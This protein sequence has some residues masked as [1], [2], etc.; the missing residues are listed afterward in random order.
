[1]FLLAS[2]LVSSVS[3]FDVYSE[4]LL[5]LKSE[6]TDDSNSLRDWV[7][8]SHE[9]PSGKIYACSWSGVKCNT[10]STAIIGLNLSVKNLAGSLSGKQF[11]LLT[12]LVD[13]N[14]SYNSFS[15]Q[16]P[17][18][19]FNL[20]NLV[21]LDISRNNFS[22]HFP[23]EV[24]GLH[25]LEV[26]DVFSN[27]FSGQLPAG[28]SEIE[29]LKV[30]NL[31]GSY[32]SGPIPSEYGSFKSLEFIHLAGNFLRGEIPPELGKLKT[33][34]HMEIG[35]NSYEGS[36]PWQ[37]GNMSELQYLDIAGANLSG[38]IPSQ[39][40]NL[41][42]LQSLFLFR[43]QLNGLIPW[44]FS[45]IK[46]LTDLDLSDNLIS[47]PIPESFS[48]LKNL[49]LLSLMYNDM[50]GTVPQGIAELPSMETLLIWNNFFTG[51]LPQNL[52]LNSNLKWVDVSTNSFNGTIPPNICV[53]G[54]LYKLILFSNNFTGD[55]QSL[56]NCSSLIRLR[57]EDNFFSGDVPLKF[58]SFP[59]LLY[60]DLSRNKFSGEFPT[61]LFQSYNL[62]Y[63]NISKN[64]DLGGTIPS[65]L[66]SLPLLQNFSASFCSIS[67]HLPPFKLC[68]SLSV[69]ELNTN[70]LSGN[71]PKGISS[72][73]ALEKIDL[74]NNNLTGHIPDELADLADLSFLD[75]SNNDFSG[76][77]PSR[78][79]FRLMGIRSF[80][81]NPNLC[82]EPLQSCNGFKLGSKSAQKLT[83]VLLLCFGL[84]LFITASILGILYFQKGR[85]GRWKMMTFT[86]L[87]KFTANDILRSLEMSPP[88]SA[89]VSKAVLPTGITVSVKKIECEVKRMV[90]MTEF[91]ARMGNARHKN[92]IRLLGFCYN[93][94]LAY[95]LYDYLPNGN[96]DEKI[97]TKRIWGEKSRI[98]IGIARG[99][100]YLHLECYPAIA[101]GN[102]KLSNVVF[103]D[104]LEPHLAEFGLKYVMQLKK[105]EYNTINKEE[106]DADI[107]SFGEIVLQILTNSK[108]TGLGAMN[109]KTNEVILREIY[110]EN[111]VTS[112]H[113]LRE[114]IKLVFEVALLCTRSRPSDRP[115]MEEVLKLLS[116]LK[117]NRKEENLK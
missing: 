99:L 108:L 48:E 79:I 18:S 25:S 104:N 63:F 89:S 77:I 27:S 114:E 29:S 9:S 93:K 20:T 43:N 102:L 21:T 82:G 33:V 10:N 52:G 94:N 70:K 16:L 23:S 57:L 68:K 32:F 7:V 86:G 81:G 67:G 40:S 98:V 60:V 83:W 80:S 65:K 13:L 62:Q 19:V 106:L 91:V 41:T 95:L 88:L 110:K 46:T 64:R 1:M 56:S 96:L 26:L 50:T 37:L 42:K 84:V 14:L 44:E 35:Y 73:Q 55:L 4:A 38:S 45:K 112:S 34:T 97:K 59:N 54:V 31:A 103:D 101:H 51:S 11:S 8:A 66:W 100:H 107:Y 61:D 105:G 22:G 5:S 6:L 75:L 17:V 36:L 58:S 12:E 116:G 69:I 71:F 113:A 87:P 24:A 53:S 85:K 15:G 111:D 30:L 49:K 39:L 74:G 90:I 3:S 2:M 92:L 117:S 47:G 72:C 76:S 28:V 115:S 78:N 109:N